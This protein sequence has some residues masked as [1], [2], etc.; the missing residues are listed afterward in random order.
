MAKNIG[1]NG[2]N[3]EENE[4]FDDSFV[5]NLTD[6]SGNVNVSEITAD[7][8]SYWVKN[9]EGYS[10]GQTNLQFSLCGN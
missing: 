4:E 2:T 6:S 7:E 9:I 8:V 3:P 5:A 10:H 1:T